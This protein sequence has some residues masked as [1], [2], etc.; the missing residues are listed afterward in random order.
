MSARD[1][2]WG[3]GLP[4]ISS[5]Q[6]KRV[7]WTDVGLW[8]I[9]VVLTSIYSNIAATIA[10]LWDVLVIQRVQD[11]SAAYTNYVGTLFDTANSALWFGNATEFA[12]NT[13][14]LGAMAIVLVG[15][16]LIA[17][18]AGVIRDG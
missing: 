5:A 2:F 10:T 1:D 12:S 9:T 3:S 17:W 4:F 14:L 6:G 13:G 16:Y 18:I 8:S 7:D 11:I 15:G